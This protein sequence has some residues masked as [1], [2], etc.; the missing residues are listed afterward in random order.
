MDCRNCDGTMKLNEKLERYTCPACG[1]IRPSSHS[2][3]SFFAKPPTPP[4]AEALE[5]EAEARKARLENM[6]KR[7]PAAQWASGELA[8]TYWTR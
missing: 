3:H 2:N 1:Y 7:S 8:D 5:R 6:D 4:S